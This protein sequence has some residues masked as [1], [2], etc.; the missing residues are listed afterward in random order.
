MKTMANDVQESNVA[1]LQRQ[2]D[3]HNKEM[4]KLKGDN[5]TTPKPAATSPTTTTTPVTTRQ[6]Q[7]LQYDGKCNNNVINNNYNIK[8]TVAVDNTAT[9]NQI[10]SLNARSDS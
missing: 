6:Q 7:R 3:R 1:I 2:K 9:T 5:T 10:A 8:I 4:E